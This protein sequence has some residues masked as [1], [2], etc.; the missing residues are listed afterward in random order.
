MFS[1]GAVCVQ[2][3]MLKLFIAMA[4]GFILMTGVVVGLVKDL[5]TR[6]TILGVLGAALGLVMYSAPL[7]IMVCHHLEHALVRL[8]FHS[9]EDGVYLGCCYFRR[10][11]FQNSKQF[12][13]VF[14][15]F[16]QRLVIQTKSVEFMPFLLSLFV[17][18][19]SATWTIYAFVPKLDVYIAVSHFHNVLC[20]KLGTQIM[21][22]NDNQ[23]TQNI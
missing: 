21:S 1:L 7:T 11:S 3:N 10:I 22:V 2:M 19:N 13:L 5:D 16:E 6:R 9:S 15:W 18:L 8:Q 14:V 4:S 12:D 20:I 23:V 17:F